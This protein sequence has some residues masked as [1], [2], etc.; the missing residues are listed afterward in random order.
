MTGGD[1]QE[2]EEGCCFVYARDS[3]AVDGW[4]EIESRG[5]LG[6]ESHAN[7]DNQF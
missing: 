6:L 3:L 7:L 2:V 5:T 4:A 1:G